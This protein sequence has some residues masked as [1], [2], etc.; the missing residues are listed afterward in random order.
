MGGTSQGAPLLAVQSLRGADG[1][2]DTAVKLLLQ[3]A[4]K[5]KKE[6][7]MALKAWKVRRERV[8]DEFMTLTSTPTL[9]P[10]EEKRLQELVTISEATPRSLAPPRLLPPRG[11]RKRGGSGEEN[12]VRGLASPHS[13]LPYWC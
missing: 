3:L 6:E 9:T 8:R 12:G 4:L 7:V 2:D 11:R 10:L 13:I 1:I 5:K